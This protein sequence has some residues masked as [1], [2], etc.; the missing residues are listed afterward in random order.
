[1]ISPHGRDAMRANG[2]GAPSKMGASL[3]K[4][5]TLINREGKRK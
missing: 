3:P 1:L 5:M 2:R 4:E